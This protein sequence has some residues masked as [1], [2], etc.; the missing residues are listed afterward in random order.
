M[1]TNRIASLLPVR[2]VGAMA[3]AGLTAAGLMVG[4]APAAHALDCADIDVVV[5]RGTNEPGWFG[6][7]VG[8]RLVEMLHDVAP[9]SVTAHRV[10]YP[11]DLLDVNSVGTGSLDLVTHV[12]DY[13]AA[14]PATRFV[15]VGYS[16]GAVVVHAALGTG[17]TDAIPGTTR[18]PAET[19]GAIAVVLLFGDPLRL[20]G[21]ELPDPYRERLGSWCAPADPVCELG[22]GNPAAHVAY[23]TALTEA[24]WFTAARL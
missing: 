20:I 21:Q 18:L 24:V 5:A 23:T 11:A 10:A 22:G 7:A 9:G 13:A 17:I 8:D 12:V 14:C 1:I 15:L 4:G 3:A 19:S 2:V 6:A 16:Q